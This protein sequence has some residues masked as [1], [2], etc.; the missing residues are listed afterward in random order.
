MCCCNEDNWPASTNG[1]S[2][3]DGSFPRGRPFQHASLAT[4]EQAVDDISH[5]LAQLSKKLHE[6][7]ELGFEEHIAHDSLTDYMRTT[8]FKVTRKAY[9]LQT[10]WKAT[11]EHGT[12]GPTIGINSEMDAL[13]DLGHA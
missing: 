7:P 10:A 4:A 1:G 2:S 11:F 9:G 8:G 12:G 3:G 5:E 13:P 6:N